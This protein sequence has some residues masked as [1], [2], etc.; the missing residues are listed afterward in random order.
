[1]ALSRAACE[2]NPLALAFVPAAV[3]EAL[4]D[5]AL[6]CVEEAGNAALSVA[7]EAMRD[8][9]D[10]VLAALRRSIAR[11]EHGRHMQ[12]LGSLAS[13]GLKANK[14]F[15]L[16]ACG[17][18]GDALYYASEALQADKDV[19]LVAVAQDGAALK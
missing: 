5:L 16:E 12:T 10:V 4:P 3:Q 2:A 14:A 19:V 7:C 6:Y 15:M 9:A 1:V 8:R 17:L 11:G 18:C 13:E